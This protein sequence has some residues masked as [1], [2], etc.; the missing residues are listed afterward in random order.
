MLLQFR[1]DMPFGGSVNQLRLKAWATINL[2]LILI[3]NGILFESLE[4]CDISLEGPKNQ[5]R[6]V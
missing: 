1:K 3:I 2:L 5:R 6:L 4:K